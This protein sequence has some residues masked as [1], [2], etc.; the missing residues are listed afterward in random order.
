MS[1]LQ[2]T[3]IIDQGCGSLFHRRFS[4]RHIHFSLSSCYWL[5]LHFCHG[6]SSY[7][8]GS[9]FRLDF[10]D[11]VDFGT[12]F[13]HW[14]RGTLR[15]DK[16]LRSIWIPYLLTVR[17]CSSF[18]FLLFPLA[19]L[20]LV[21]F[22]KRL[23]YQFDLLLSQCRYSL[24]LRREKQVICVL[25]ND[26]FSLCPFENTDWI[27]GLIFLLGNWHELGRPRNYETFANFFYLGVLLAFLLGRDE[28]LLGETQLSVL[29][30]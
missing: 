12:V 26:S 29:V 11:P 8:I 5:E 18:Q 24:H 22:D 27:S 3:L 6:S 15:N 9:V 4:L 21:I 7:K 13:T 23:W 25:L 16:T 1:L 14:V 30:E 20:F 10:I 2:W 28:K 17:T 19:S